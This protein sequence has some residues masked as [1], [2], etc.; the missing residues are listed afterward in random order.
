MPLGLAHALAA[1]SDT[2]T[3]KDCAEVHGWFCLKFK[4]LSVV[5]TER[6]SHYEERVRKDFFMV[7]DI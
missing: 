6:V 5:S 4:H 3:I 2:Q 1:L 7:L